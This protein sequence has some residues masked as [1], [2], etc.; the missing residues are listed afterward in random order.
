MFMRFFLLLGL[1]MCC[2]V[3]LSVEE[4]HV[5]SG[6]PKKFSEPLPVRRLGPLSA[7]LDPMAVSLLDMVPRVPDSKLKT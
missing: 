1:S 5:P 3:V 2:G 7:P 6:E 4:L